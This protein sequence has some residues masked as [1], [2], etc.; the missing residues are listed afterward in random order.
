MSQRL[1]PLSRPQ[2]HKYQER[3][4]AQGAADGVQCCPVAQELGGERGVSVQGGVEEAVK[5]EITDKGSQCC[6]D[7]DSLW[8]KARWSLG[9][10]RRTPDCWRLPWPLFIFLFFDR[11]R[12][13]Q[14][15]EF[16]INCPALSP[17]L[18]R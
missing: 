15:D 10:L 11:R 6:L 18:L 7:V 3:R 12:R 5:W 8:G 1:S 14:Q 9:V 13:R 4:E 2:N 16:A 17:E